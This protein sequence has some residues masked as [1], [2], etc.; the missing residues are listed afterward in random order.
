[1]QKAQKLS[2]TAARLT[3][4]VTIVRMKN[5]P[6]LSTDNLYQMKAEQRQQLL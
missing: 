5:E 1:M 2:T 6:E 4:K 3:A